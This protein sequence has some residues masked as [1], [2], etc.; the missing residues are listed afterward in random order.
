[1]KEFKWG[2]VIIML[3]DIYYVL[4]N[5]QLHKGIYSTVK[6]FKIKTNRDRLQHFN[7]DLLDTF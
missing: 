7:P 2:A 6:A 3:S 1:M 4:I 5:E